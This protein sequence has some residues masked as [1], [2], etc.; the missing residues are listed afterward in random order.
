MSILL[1]GYVFVATGLCSMPLP[2]P[3]FA[4]Q[5]YTAYWHPDMTGVCRM[6]T[7]ADIRVVCPDP[8]QPGEDMKCR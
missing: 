6:P 3:L 4:I 5:T 7:E 8:Q 2:K 1:A